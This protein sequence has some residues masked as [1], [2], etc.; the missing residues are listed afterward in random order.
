MSKVIYKF[1]RVSILQRLK[2]SNNKNFY[3]KKNTLRIF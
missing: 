3:I 2:N 1:M